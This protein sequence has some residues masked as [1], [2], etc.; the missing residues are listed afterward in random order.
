MTNLL[1]LNNLKDITNMKKLKIKG[2]R[3]Y[4]NNLKNLLCNLIFNILM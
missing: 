4:K 1:Q 3:C 2:P